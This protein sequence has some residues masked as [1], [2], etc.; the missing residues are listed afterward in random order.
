MINVT[1]SGMRTVGLMA[2]CLLLTTTLAVRADGDNKGKSHKKSPV[3]TWRTT[4]VI[5]DLGI[6]DLPGLMTFG[7]GAKS[8]DG[9]TVVHSD[10][11]FVNPLAGANC[12]P[13]QGVWE[14]TGKRTFIGTDE[15]FCEDLVGFTMIRSK[16]SL[17]LNESGTK[18]D[19]EYYVELLDANGD[20][21]LGFVAGFGK[22][23][24][25][26][27]EAEAP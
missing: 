13:L 3:G 9:G 5:A 11:G 27:M 14:K 8:H 18:F 7:P 19:G 1:K 10:P 6:F 26:R 23:H 12:L 15:T 21:F 25:V 16:F 22:I 2:I 20:I 24:G 4:E 17:T